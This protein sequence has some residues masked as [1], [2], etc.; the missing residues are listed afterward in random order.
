[1]TSTGKT[2]V[3]VA[4]ANSIGVAVVA[5]LTRRGA[6][7]TALD[8][9]EADLGPCHAVADGAPGAIV[10]RAVDVTDWDAM[11]AAAA[12]CAAEGLDVLV[13]CHM[14]IEWG[15][16]EVLTPCAWERSLRLNLFGPIIAGRAFAPALRRARGAV[17]HIG[18]VDGTY[19]NPHAAAYSTCKGG[20]GPLTHVM[21][22][23]FGPDG[24]RVNCV[25][26]AAV[27]NP[28][29]VVPLGYAEAMAVTPLARSAHPDEVAA[30]VCYLAS[31][32]AS[33]ITGTTLVVDGG[34]TGLTA[35]TGWRTTDAQK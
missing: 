28:E 17:V 7:V 25:A 6:A 33:Y 14:G 19:G 1:V 4:A 3:V 34:R 9:P 27:E 30:A 2:A 5:A 15:S 32:E 13:T 16:F 29:A 23:A 12:G 8:S 24:V 11:H 22:H 31:P 26:R 18:S 10:T 21:A 35:G 20:I